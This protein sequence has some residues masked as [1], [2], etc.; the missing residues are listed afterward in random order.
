MTCYHC[1]K[2]PVMKTSL[3]CV[4]CWGAHC[5]NEKVLKEP[6]GA[7]LIRRYWIVVAIA[8][9]G[10]LLALLAIAELLSLYL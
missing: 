4:D 6:V 7:P 1:G 10:W 8:A 5:F 9:L 3:Y 2:R